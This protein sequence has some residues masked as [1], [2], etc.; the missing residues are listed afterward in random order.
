M[1]RIRNP[2][3]RKNSVGR[4]AW[5]CGCDARP[6]RLWRSLLL[7]ITL[8][9]AGCTTASPPKGRGDLLDFVVDGRTTKPE[10]LAALGSPSGRF[11][12]GKIVTYRLG[13]ER[14]SNGYY[15]VEREVSPDGW[16][17]WTLTTFSLVLVF[18]ETDVLQRHSLVKVNR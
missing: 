14:Q 15:V 11:E 3:P 9:I 2:K 13:Y 4:L 18:D 1:N 16:P 17:M 6:G 5:T 8:S 10:A 12:S 7:L